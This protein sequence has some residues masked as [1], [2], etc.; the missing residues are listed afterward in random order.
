MARWLQFFLGTGIV[1]GASLARA[2]ATG[3]GDAS[4]KAPSPRTWAIELNPLELELARASINLELAPATHHALML[5]FDAQPSTADIGA[6]VW[7]ELGYRFYAG[8]GGLQGLFVG[9]AIGGGMF[10]YFTDEVTG[11]QSARSV[12]A[13]FDCGYQFALRSGVTLG[14]GL[15]V[16]YQ[17]VWH[18]HDVRND[19]VNEVELV[20]GVLPR[21]LFSVGYGG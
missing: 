17:H 11:E 18:D 2:Q 19:P 16:Q 13:A 10:T 14:F 6:G 5:T 15:G 1:C 8:D 20:S 3:E 4:T 12:N 7:G 9:P 21:L